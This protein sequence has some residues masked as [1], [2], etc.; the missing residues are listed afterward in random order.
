MVAARATAQVVTELASF[1]AAA[2]LAAASAAALAA[3][4]A[5]ALAAAASAT[6]LSR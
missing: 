5:A 3:A 4:S 6:F 1:F 2:A